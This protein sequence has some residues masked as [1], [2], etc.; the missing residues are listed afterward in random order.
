MVF[1]VVHKLPGR[2]R[3]RFDRHSLNARQAELVRTLVSLQKGIDFINVNPVS[4]GIL[5]EYSGISEKT[6]LSYIRALDDSYLTNEELLSAVSVPEAQES[7]AA[8]LFPLVA[9]F[10]IRKLLP[11]PIRS[12]LSLVSIIPRLKKGAAAVLSGKPFCADTLD[13]TALS[14]SYASGDINTAN[15]IT[16]L[17]NM[18]EVLEDYTKRKSY[19]NLTRSFLNLNEQVQVIRSGEEM[20]IPVR[21]LKTGD[22]VVVR[23]G[24]VIPADGTVVSGE[25]SVNQASM[26]GESLAVRKAL[27]SSVFASTIV[28][29]GEIYV[30]VKA[31][32]S[33]TR[34]SKIAQMIEHSQSLKAGIQ[35]KAER[36]ADK[37]VFY[38]FMLAAVTYAV[39]RDFAKAASTLL[40]DY[41][42]AM[43]LAAPVAVLAA[44]KSC[45]QAGITVKGGKFLEDF[46]R[47]DT[48]V[49]D[50]TGTLTESVPA[51][52]KITTFGGANE[53]EVLKIAACLEEHFPHP[54]ARAV[55]KEAASRGIK[56]RE[57]HTT[58]SYIAAHGLASTLNDAQLRIGSAH[59]IFDDEKIP[60]T[61]EVKRAESD[62]AKTGCSLLYLAVNGTLAGIIAIEDPVRTEAKQVIQTLYNAGIQNIIMLT[63]D[64]EKTAK[65]IAEK[66]GIRTYRAQV[67]PDEKS[68]FIEKLKNQGHR[69]VMIGD[70]INDSPALSAADVGIAMGQAASIASETADILLPDNGLRALVNLHYIGSRLIERIK[71]NNAL[72]VGINSALIAAELSSAVSA[73]SAA[74]LHNG[75][76]L[77]IGMAAM[78]SFGKN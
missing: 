58:V 60:K 30:K 57:E 17:L 65:T 27:H 28:E 22:T 36:T 55:V 45:A 6:A 61:D 75:S 51:V 35:I 25:A 40:V 53:R 16:M 32:G 52:K 46:I 78:R 63:G 26:T 49:F 8:V 59:F 18:G 62:L 72:I 19:D 21:M 42:C 50:K 33:E 4:C 77:A 56:H 38:N 2:L 10:F 70:G 64:G 74:L 43:K 29:E 7:L 3:L 67:L 14:L 9:Q 71:I 66:L 73:S 41:S 44:M 31:C 11:L 23:S 37:L 48:I 68:Q 69:V 12:V 15:T 20:P 76:T 47:A 24:S 5:L 13:A 34:I 54:L 39:T 1:S